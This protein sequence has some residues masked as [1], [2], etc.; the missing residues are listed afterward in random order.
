MFPAVL[1]SGPEGGEVSICS[2]EISLTTRRHSLRSTGEELA[3][4]ASL[5]GGATQVKM[6]SMKMRIPTQ[7]II[8]V[9]ILIIGGGLV[10]GEYLLVKWYPGHVQRVNEEVLKQDPYHNDELGVDIQVARGLY[11]RVETFPGG[12]KISRRKFW[13]VGP[14][15]TITSESN[16]DQTSVFAEEVLAKWQTKGALED[17][18]R[19]H[20]ERTKIGNRDSVL[21]RQYKGRSMLLTGR[22]L[23]PER[24]IE[25][26]C[27]PGAE[28]EVLYMQ[29]CDETLASIKVADPETP[30]AAEPGVLELTPAP[31]IK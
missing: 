9:S 30:P 28:D 20:F 1:H 27:T 6:T 4:A 29:V 11:G 8:G 7:L 10:G 26:N 31:T 21:I 5:R 15:L 14:S 23:T 12:V 3:L 13:S 19:Y 18:P 16:P 22:I 24:I 25:A 17:I 2:D